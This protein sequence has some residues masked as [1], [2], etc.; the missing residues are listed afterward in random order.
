MKDSKKSRAKT[1]IGESIKYLWLGMAIAFLVLSLILTKIGWGNPAFPFFTMLYGLGTYVS[2]SILK[3]RPLTI[4]GLIASLLAVAS[5]WAA[6]DYQMLFG[7]A[8]ILV[9]YIIPAHILRA[10]K[11]SSTSNSFV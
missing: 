10:R 5:A 8:A 9:S 4:G 1:Y 6:Y 3:F 11:S 7:A 2:G